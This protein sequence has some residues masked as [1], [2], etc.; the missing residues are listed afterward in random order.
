VL[1]IVRQVR[2]AAGPR[3]KA[4]GSGRVKRAGD[5]LTTAMAVTS[6][7]LQPLPFSTTHVVRRL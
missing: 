4:A 2:A 6:G 3:I 7:L 5:A 1:A